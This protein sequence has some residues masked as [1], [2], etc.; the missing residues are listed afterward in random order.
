MAVGPGSSAT[1]R[2]GVAVRALNLRA[3][4]TARLVSSEPADPGR[5][6]EVVLDPARGA[7]LPAERRAFDDERLETLGRPVHRGS[8]AGRSAADHDQ[9][10]LLARGELEPDPERTRDLA[11]GRVAQLDPAGEPHE[12]HVPGIEPV[13]Q[14]RVARDRRVL[15]VVP[16]VRQPIAPGELDDPP[17]RL[18]RAR[19]DD[20]HPDV[21]LLERLAS[22]HEGRQQ[23]VAQRAVLEQQRAQLVAVDGDVP[24]RL[25]DHRRQVHGLARE[26]VHLAQEARRRVP[27]DLVPGRVQDRGLA[28]ENRDERIARVADPEQHVTDRGAALLAVRGQRCKL[29]RRQGRARRWTDHPLSLAHRADRDRRA[30]NFR[31]APAGYRSSAP[32]N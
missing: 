2:Y 23:Q 4:V 12:R 32:P 19:T 7:G 18:R 6:A 25:R 22:R 27:H 9:V 30:A 3:W 14:R 26:E 16:G 5:E 20:L 24:H 11:A 21:L 8:E 28:L 17:R 29:R 15:R 31:T 13:D 10:D 1:A